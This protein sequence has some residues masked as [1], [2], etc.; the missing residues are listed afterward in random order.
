MAYNYDHLEVGDEVDFEEYGC[1]IGGNLRGWVANKKEGLVRIIWCKGRLSNWFDNVCH[2]NI[3]H[4]VV[5]SR[6]NPLEVY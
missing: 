6:A 1:L 5:V 2:S 4:W 3:R